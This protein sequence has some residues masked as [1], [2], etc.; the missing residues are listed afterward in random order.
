MKVIKLADTFG[1]LYAIAKTMLEIHGEYF[2]TIE[3]EQVEVIK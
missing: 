2:C 1:L 3:G